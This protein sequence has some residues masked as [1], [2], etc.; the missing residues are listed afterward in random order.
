MMKV[1]ELVGFKLKEV[2]LREPT[3]LVT[4]AG[5]PNIEKS[6]LI[7]FIHKIAELHCPGKGFRNYILINLN[8][9]FTLPIWVLKF[10]WFGLV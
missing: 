5:V 3:L 9:L 2:I 1:L 6:T 7:N 4:V 8:D 10:T